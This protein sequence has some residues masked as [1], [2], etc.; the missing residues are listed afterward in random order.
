MGLLVDGI[1]HDKWYDTSK[2]GGRFVRSDA[3][4]RN[5]VTPDG[6]AG[7][8]GSGGFKAEPDRYHLYVS[9]ACPWA[10]RTLIYRALKDLNDMISVSVVHWYMADKGWTFANDDQGIVGDRLFGSDF[11]HQIYTKADP[12]FSGRVTVPILWDKQT[13]TIVSNESSEII[14]MFNSAF[15]GIGAKPGD[16]YPQAKREKIDALNDRIYNTFNNGVY[17]C[18]FSTTQSAYNEAIVPLFDTLE[19][20]DSHLGNSRFLTGEEPTEADWRLLPT[21]LRFDPIYHSHFKCNLKRLIDYPNLWPFTR[22]LFQWPGISETFN[23]EHARRHYFESHETINPNRILPIGAEI[24]F[25]EPH[26]RG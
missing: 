14:R 2:S 13:E 22:D 1:W 10:H 6:A 7:V 18:G 24:D 17:Q 20:L 5:W 26:G 9:F 16:Y 4:F 19:F 11:A 21:L 15:D 23:I 25:F 3:Q 8:S 12:K